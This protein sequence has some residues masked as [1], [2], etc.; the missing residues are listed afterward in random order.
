MFQ[1]NG[2]PDYVRICIEIFQT[3]YLHYCHLSYL[4]C[5]EIRIQKLTDV[6][7]T[8][9]LRILFQTI[10]LR[11][12]SLLCFVSKAVFFHYF[13]ILRELLLIP[14]CLRF[15][16]KLDFIEFY[17]FLLTTV[18]LLIALAATRRIFKLA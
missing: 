17:C 10:I 9:S 13:M 2:N 11:T 14:I 18:E 3:K 7:N 15:L 5:L 1:S 12:F 6:D 4:F 8:Q 16:T